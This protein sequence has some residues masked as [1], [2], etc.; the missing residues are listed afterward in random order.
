MLISTHEATLRLSSSG[1][2]LPWIG[3]ALRGLVAERFKQAVCRQPA[4]L[5]A[6]QWKVCKG[7]EFLSECAYGALFEPDPPAEAEVFQGQEEAV[8]PVVLAPYFP[9]PTETQRGL[10]I[11]LRIV[12][13]GPHAAHDA[14]PL[15]QMIANVGAQRGLGPEHVTFDLAAGNGNG[16]QVLELRP[17][18]LPA[19]PAAVPGVLPRVG[20][21]LVS[22]LLLRS[23]K[24]DG[25][26]RSNTCPEL[27]DLLRPALRTISHLFRL[28]GEPLDAD[29][30]ALKAAAEGIRLVEHCYEPFQQRKWS[31]RTEHRF[32]IHGVVGG[33][34]YADV[35]LAL[36]PWLV[37]GG[38]LHVG[39]HRV[40]GAGGWR[41]VL[42]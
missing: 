20:I 8:R 22:P 36:L 28:Y 9:V 18:D 15:L 1:H 41:V 34:V 24:D 25:R 5:Q 6:S 38:R 35:P 23:R 39:N 10:E 11:P 32:C 29:F 7:C 31:S 30:R 12:L 17:Q 4:E 33:G 26:R 42:D 13:V 40:A 2:L 37:W 27:V 19:H 3:P 16:R 14:K 21:G